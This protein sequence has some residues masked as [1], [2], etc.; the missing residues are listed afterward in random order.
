MDQAAAREQP[1]QGITEEV[2]LFYKR[3][4]KAM[5]A[6]HKTHGNFKFPVT[7]MPDKTLRWVNR[8]ERRKNMPREEKLLRQAAV[9]MLTSY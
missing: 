7:E 2:V 1:L 9:R 6:W 4:E 3:Y 5:G 8:A